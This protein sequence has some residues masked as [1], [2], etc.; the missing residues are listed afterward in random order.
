MVLSWC[1]ANQQNVRGVSGVFATMMCSPFLSVW[2]ALPLLSFSVA[3]SYAMWFGVHRMGRELP[4]PSID[5]FLKMRLAD[6]V[7]V[8]ALLDAFWEALRGEG[9]VVLAT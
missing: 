6:G 3:E 7:R 2:R 8:G 5:S 1:C 9:R 4:A